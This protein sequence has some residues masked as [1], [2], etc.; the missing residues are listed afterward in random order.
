MYK[1]TYDI[2]E[3]DLDLE[4]EEEEEDFYLAPRGGIDAFFLQTMINEY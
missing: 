2:E 4:E 3:I 1:S